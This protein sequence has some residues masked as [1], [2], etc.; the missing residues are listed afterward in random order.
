VKRTP[1]DYQKMFLGLQPPGL[2][3][4]KRLQSNW[5]KLWLAGGDG[6]ARL[7]AEVYRLLREANPLYADASLEEWEAVTGLPDECTVPGEGKD[8]RRA[9]VIAKL[10]RPGGQSID[11]FLQF[12]APFGDKIEITEDFPP[13][14]A[15][16]SVI[17]DRTWEYPAGIMFDENGD[18]FQDWYHGWVF[19]WK[20][21]RTNHKGRRFRTGRERAGDKLVVWNGSTDEV[22]ANLE[23]RINQLKPAH[24]VVMFEY[25]LDNAG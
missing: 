18:Q 22:D 2:A 13:F 25:K 19:V 10:Q 20:V 8:S 21:I 16:V 4:N 15:S 14:L 24:T 9:A 1:E 11:F 3:W 23:C 7:E 6:L 17:D 12:L 5:A